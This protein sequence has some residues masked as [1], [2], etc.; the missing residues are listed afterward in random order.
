MPSAVADCIAS[1]SDGL[2]HRP[3]RIGMQ[4]MDEDEVV[5]PNVSIET[6]HRVSKG[7]QSSLQREVY[8]FQ[9]AQ[10]LKPHRTDTRSAG[11]RKRGL[12]L[13]HGGDRQASIEQVS[14]TKQVPIRAYVLRRSAE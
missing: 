8:G 10:R 12:R 9:P 1:R 7:F 13:H 4:R 3:Q 6:R 11:S 14:V 2:P 5:G